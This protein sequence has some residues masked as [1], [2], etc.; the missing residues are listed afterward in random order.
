MLA[1]CLHKAIE[2]H[3]NEMFLKLLLNL[4]SGIIIRNESQNET[5]STTATSTPEPSNLTSKFDA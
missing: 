2:A 5:I 4:V 1:L 3:G